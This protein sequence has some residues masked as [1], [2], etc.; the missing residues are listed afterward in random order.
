MTSCSGVAEPGA[1]NARVV[2]SYNT[3]ISYSARR[4]KYAASCAKACSA[5]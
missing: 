2:A 4:E 1:G 5:C 3:S